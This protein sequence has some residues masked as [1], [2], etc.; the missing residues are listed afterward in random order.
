MTISAKFDWQQELIHAITN[1]RELCSELDLNL[2]DLNLSQASLHKFQLKVPRNFVKRMTK[3]NIQDPLL[4]QVL[5]FSQEDLPTPDYFVDPLQE[6]N[7]N[8]LPGLL[9]KYKG[10]VLLTL[11]GTC[12]IHCRF[13]FRQHFDY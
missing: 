2:S 10:R 9:H 7:Q 12:A 3:N 5:P 6:K 11:T 4:Q 8:P 13:C 1:P